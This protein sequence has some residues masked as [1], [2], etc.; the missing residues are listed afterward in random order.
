MERFE[1]IYY[2]LITSRLKKNDGIMIYNWQDYN[3]AKCNPLPRLYLEKDAAVK[4]KKK[5]KSDYTKAGRHER[6]MA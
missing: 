2:A 5:G 4:S 6:E 1:S 3:K